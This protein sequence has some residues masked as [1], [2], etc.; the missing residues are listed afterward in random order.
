MITHEYVTHAHTPEE[1][2]AEL[3]GDLIR[4]IAALD[5]YSRNVAKGA[6]ERARIA[7]AIEELADMLNYWKTIRI[8]RAKGKRELAREARKAESI[9][10]SVPLPHISTPL[11]SEH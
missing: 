8:D 5:S 9:S 11:R 7:R 6:S 1:L 4:R 2:K 3:V 10:G